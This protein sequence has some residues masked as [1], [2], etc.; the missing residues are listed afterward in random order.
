MK[1]IFLVR[2]FLKK[3]ILNILPSI[4]LAGFTFV[5]HAETVFKVAY[6]NASQF[7][8]YLGD[9]SKVLEKPGAAVE[10]V[11]LL[12]QEIPGLKIEFYRYPW[13][14]C[15]LK[16]KAG[17]I[18]G[19]FNGSFTKARLDVGTY[20]WKNGA[21]DDTRRLTTMSY[22]FYKLKGAPFDWDGTHVLG[23][24]RQIGT[25]LAFSIEGDLKEMGLDILSAREIQINFSNL[26]RHKVDA[27]AL[28][29]VTGDY[30]I[31][32]KSGLSSVEKVQ[33]ELKTKAYYLML[34]KQFYK[35]NPELSEQIWD[36]I[37]KLREEKLQSLVESYFE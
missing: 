10:L 34:S 23:L 25:P 29:S 16:L 5:C 37:A 30:H 15:L 22:H 21:V 4:F 8:N 19:A 1:A 14:Q 27:I 28:Q 33:P 24:K 36:A 17:E 6:E 7:P 26:L 31:S 18:D 11:K 2:W 12:E 35:Q 13:K 9:T 3:S 32:T 20:P